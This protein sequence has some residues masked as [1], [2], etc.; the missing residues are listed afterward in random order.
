MAKYR[1][2]TKLAKV[3]S[4][5]R[6][7]L[8]VSRFLWTIPTP[9]TSSSCCLPKVVWVGFMSGLSKSVEAWASRAWQ[10]FF[11]LPKQPPLYCSEGKRASWDKP[12]SFTAC[13]RAKVGLD[14]S[15]L[16]SMAHEAVGY[17]SPIASPTM[18]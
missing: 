8:S 11:F 4:L 15:V 14:Y 1:L 10:W 6:T 2:L 16:L 5:G 13:P 7:V 3:V 17:K 9:L 18:N 12:K